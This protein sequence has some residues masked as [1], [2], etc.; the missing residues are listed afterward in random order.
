MKILSLKI[1]KCN[2]CPYFREYYLGHSNYAYHCINRKAIRSP[3]DNKLRDDNS[4]PP[5]WCPLQNAEV[6]NNC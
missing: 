6:T 5:D 3:G 4:I 2:E 1:E